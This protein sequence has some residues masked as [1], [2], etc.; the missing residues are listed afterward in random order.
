MKKACLV[1]LTLLL[2]VL[3]SCRSSHSLTNSSRSTN[4]IYVERGEEY[5]TVKKGQL[6]FMAAGLDADSGDN[7]FIFAIKNESDEKYQFKDTQ[8]RIYGGNADRNRWTL[9]DTWN[10]Q[11]FYNNT[12]KASAAGFIVAT[13]AGVLNVVDA[14]LQFFS[15][16]LVYTPFGYAYVSTDDLDPG[17][18]VLTAMIAHVAARHYQDVRKSNMDYLRD[19]LLYSSTINPGDV[20]SGLVYFPTDSEYADYKVVF[21]DNDGKKEEFWFSRTDREEILHPWSADATRPLNALS[22]NFAPMS[23]KYG[24]YYFLLPPKGVGIYTGISF[25]DF[26]SDSPDSIC[27]PLGMTIKVAEHTWLTAGVGLAMDMDPEPSFDEPA[28]GVEAQGGLNFAY[29]FLD[30]GMQFNYDF[31]YDRFSFDVTAG[32][33]L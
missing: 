21:E 7:R 27:T 13:V 4:D 29:N 10:A 9:I 22:F 18:V 31:L 5:Q 15:Q 14:S 2:L 23:D 24:F 26:F 8:I 19:N 20:Y 25:Y 11:R 3:C 32:L 12:R 30:F 16:T 17:D 1:L 33:A 28:F 6:T